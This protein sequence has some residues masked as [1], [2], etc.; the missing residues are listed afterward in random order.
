MSA[1]M[2]GSSESS[3]MISKKA[4]ESLEMRLN[5]RMPKPVLEWVNEVGGSAF[6]RDIIYKFQLTERSRYNG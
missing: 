1:Y 4:C 3:L 5:V 6:V 2:K